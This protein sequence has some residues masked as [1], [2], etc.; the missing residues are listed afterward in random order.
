MDPVALNARNPGAMTGTGNWTWLIPG[1]VPTL[2]DAGV[3]DQGHLDDLERALGAAPLAQVLVTHG[4]ADHA[5]GTVAISERMPSV[6]FMKLPWPDRDHRW[7][8]KWTPLHDHDLIEAG[9]VS[10]SV[11]HTPGHAPD[12]ACFWHA[13]SGILFGGDLAIAHTT[14]WIPSSLD[15]DLAQYV[16][17]LQR[18]IALQPSRILPAHGPV[19][20]D[21][22]SVLRGYITHRRERERQILEAL[23]EG[24]TT[25][26]AI[27][28]RIY[29]R[30]SRHLVPRAAE[31]VTAH[32]VKLERE[33]A[34]RR[35]G[36]AWHII[37]P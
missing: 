36:D 17:S 2:I 15:G 20:D 3:G 35:D 25:P 11:V 12:H 24:V 34:V 30:L 6:R 9:D 31:T 19:I 37:G 18:V 13:A 27:V 10:L 21:P 16:A 33:L 8:V 1:R 22:V 5:A 4:H 7:P 32:L 14:V 26:L 23:G 28:A 29:P